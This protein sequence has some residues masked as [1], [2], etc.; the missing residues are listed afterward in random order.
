MPANAT[1]SKLHIKAYDSGILADLA[2]AA[3][4]HLGPIAR[5]SLI[6]S[7]CFCFPA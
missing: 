6:V 1:L 5:G 3:D 2:H 4:E 7:F